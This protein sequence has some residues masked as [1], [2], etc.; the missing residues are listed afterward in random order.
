MRPAV[1]LRDDFDVQVVMASFELVLKADVGKMHA[2]IEV[3]HVMLARPLL[4]F[5]RVSIGSTV[6]VRALAIAL[7][8]LGRGR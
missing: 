8:Q 5:A 3:G 7:L 2:V 1:V 4:D 6:A